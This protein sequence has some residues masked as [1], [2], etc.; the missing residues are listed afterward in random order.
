MLTARDYLTGIVDYLKELSNGSDEQLETVFTE[1]SDIESLLE[2]M[3]A[4][5]FDNEKS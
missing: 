2:Q 1:L 5:L 3:C 4:E